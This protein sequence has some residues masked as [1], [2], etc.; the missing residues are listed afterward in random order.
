MLHDNRGGIMKALPRKTVVAC[1]CAAAAGAAI[2]VA[3]PASVFWG[4]WGRT[5]LHQGFAPV[6]GQTGSNIL[7]N[8]VYDP[9]TQKEQVGNYAAGD[10]LVHYQTPL[11][12][13]NDVFMECK[14]G[15]FTNIKHWQAQTWCEQK[16]TWVNGQLQLQWTHINDWKPVPFSVDKDGPGWEPVYHAVLTKQAI[17]VP[18]FGGA[19]WK[20][21]RDDGS[22]LAH[23][24]PFG[25]TL[26]PNTYAVGPLSADSNGNVYYNVMQLDGSANDPWLV[27]VPRS[28]LVKVTA[29]G[30]STA[31]PWASLVS[32][33]DT[34]GHAIPAAN[35]QC[36]WRYSDADLPWPVLNAGG[37]PAEPLN[38]T[39][40]S[41]RPPVNT[42][43]A[44]GPDGTIYDI[45]RASLDDYFSYVVAINPNLTTKWIASMRGKFNDGC[46]TATLPPNGAPGGCR[47][48]APAGVSPPTGKAGDGR[49]IDDS[50]SAPVVAPDGSIYYGAYTRY[51][52]AQGHMM[53]WSSSGQYLPANNDA[54][55]GFQF[56]WDITPAIFPYTAAD[57]SATFAVVTKENHYGDVGSYCNDNKLCP[58]DRTATNPGYPEEYFVASLKPDLSLNWRFQNMNTQSCS[59]NSDG[60]LSCVSDHPFGFE[61]CVNAPGVDVNGTV[62][63]NSE[64]GNLYEIGRNGNLLNQVFTQLAIGAA[65]TPLSIGPDGKIYTQNDG[66]LFV[67]GN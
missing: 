11:I 5:P 6:A 40:G 61:W 12:A 25:A 35:D 55:S 65:Y 17:W 37:S 67:V 18:A 24:T 66:R 56:G 16:F 33:V 34:D 44:I 52:Y 30:V 50:T 1:L 20:L 13:G 31:K 14:T 22:V 49:V 53:R 60:T 46:G 41:Q 54:L 59:R 21:S 43:P 64:D 2:A 62:F 39:C 45:S 57:G 42:A 51:N 29:S 32:G 7:A 36:P 3:P 23:V 63:A 48:G 19:L 4:Q 26:D 9:F 38:V 47:A 27:D 15:Q 58:P 28:W 10:L 8:I